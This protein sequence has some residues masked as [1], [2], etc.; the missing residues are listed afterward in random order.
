MRGTCGRPSDA[1]EGG[2]NKGGGT[3]L[4]NDHGGFTLPSMCLGRGLQGSDSIM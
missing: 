4:R 1:A 3:I 2:D